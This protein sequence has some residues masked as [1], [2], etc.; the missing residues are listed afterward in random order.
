MQRNLKDL[1]SKQFII[2]FV[3]SS[4]SLTN[5]KSSPMLRYDKYLIMFYLRALQV[6]KKSDILSHLDFLYIKGGDI[7]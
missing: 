5:R 1:G 2:S 7:K 3:I 4:I 6:F